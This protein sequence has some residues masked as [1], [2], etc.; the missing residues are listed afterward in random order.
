MSLSRTLL[1]G[2][3]ILAAA[4]GGELASPMQETNSSPARP[5]SHQDPSSPQAPSSSHPGTGVADDSYIPDDTEV[6]EAVALDLG[7]AANLYPS[8][9]APNSDVLDRCRQPVPGITHAQ[10]SDTRYDE[11]LV[12]SSQAFEVSGSGEWDD[13]ANY[14]RFLNAVAQAPVHE[15][16]NVA[17]RQ[18][19]VVVDEG[20]RGVGNCVLELTDATGTSA[21]LITSASGRVPVFPEL[22]GFEGPVAVTARCLSQT[23]SATLSLESVDEVVTMK[24]AAAREEHGAK[25]IDLAFVLDVTG[26]MSAEIEAMKQT[27]DAV[28]TEIVTTGESKVRLALVAYRDYGDSP[29]FQTVDFTEDLAS[30]REYVAALRAE[31]GGD[32]PEAVNEAMD[33]ATRLDWDPDATARMTFV[34]ADAPPHPNEDSSAVQAAAVLYCAGVK[35]F[36]VATTGQSPTGRFI[37]RQM[38]QLTSATHLF[39]LRG[40]AAPDSDCADYEFRTDELHNLVI[41]RIKEELASPDQDPLDIPGLGS[42][43]DTDVAEALDECAKEASAAAGESLAPLAR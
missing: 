25:T 33:W 34:I 41:E 12:S 4:C 8:E 13:N 17:Q 5:R 43:R 18:F 39:L 7:S 6:G 11:S 38:S 14:R 28:A 20:G 1:C 35:V 2:S 29:L 26:S 31:G 30:F 37:F 27:I 40:G 22:F 42:D 15:T 10:E 32:T 36:T 9:P 24:L 23:A 3:L 21:T 16:V 19:V